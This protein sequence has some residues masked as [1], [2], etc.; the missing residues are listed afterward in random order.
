M[1]KQYIYFATNDENKAE[2][3]GQKLNQLFE[4]YN[5]TIYSSAYKKI[6]D[7]WDVLDELDLN[8][9][10][11]TL[12]VFDSAVYTNQNLPEVVVSNKDNYWHILKTKELYPWYE[13]VLR[14]PLITPIFLIQKKE[15]FFK[16][17][18]EID[19]FCYID[20]S[21]PENINNQLE[22]NITLFLNGFRT[23]FDPF[24]LRKKWRDRVLRAMFKDEL[25][26]NKQTPIERKAK[27][28]YCIEDEIEYA[29]FSGYTAY[30]YGAKVSIVDSYAV[31]EWSREKV[32]KQNSK[33]VGIIR[34]LDLRFRDHTLDAK[35]RNS[36]KN[37]ENLFPKNSKVDNLVI[38][39][40][41]KISDDD[42]QIVKPLNSLYKIVEKCHRL[43]LNNKRILVFES[44]KN[45]SKDDKN[46]HA[47]PYLNMQLSKDILAH[48]K[49]SD[50]SYSNKVFKALLHME[51]YMLLGNMAP[52][53]SMQ[54]LKDLH[55]A[56]LDFELSFI[57]IDKNQTIEDRKKDVEDDIER[58]LRGINNP[59]LKDSFL[60]SFWNDAKTIY[61]KHE[62]FNASE[63]ANN[64]AMMLIKW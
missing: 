32:A 51:A 8:K 7:F 60:I 53:T 36:L 43:D 56:E 40:H 62:Q 47:A 20:I 26:E 24:G 50:N 42:Y 46:N 30:K 41:V 28:I 13:L 16:H 58:L 61:K 57:G 39:S 33:D 31:L 37:M 12:V 27:S 55:L 63:E 59:K 18:E 3:I 25:N 38:S 2:L 23:W 29:L 1:K 52:T 45:K 15:D 64:E 9:Q 14:Y 21:I 34:D 44:Q 54:I 4:Y 22:K 35:D 49:T 10:S 17:I 19:S 48:T 6:Y 5:C 11:N